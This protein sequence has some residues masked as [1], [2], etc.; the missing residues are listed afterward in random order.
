MSVSR[1]P[2]CEGR[3]TSTHTKNFQDLKYNIEALIQAPRRRV[4]L[5]SM[6]ELPADDEL[7]PSASPFVVSGPLLS[8]CTSVRGLITGWVYQDFLGR[9]LG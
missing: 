4:T 2:Y 5:Q 6:D 3:K 1:K 9:V 8:L 7:D